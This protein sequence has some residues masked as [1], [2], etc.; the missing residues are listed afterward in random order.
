MSKAWPL[1]LTP[2][3]LGN[4]AHQVALKLAD[5]SSADAAA[6]HCRLVA[7]G[8]RPGRSSFHRWALL[9]SAQSLR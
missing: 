1:P 8:L 7:T 5:F 2:S 9:A 6:E 4:C 3:A